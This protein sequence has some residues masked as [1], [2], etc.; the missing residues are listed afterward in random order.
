MGGDGCST[1]CEVETNFA[2]YGSSM[3]KSK[4]I[5]LKYDIEIKLISINKVFMSNQGVF[6]FK[7]TPFLSS[8]LLLDLDKAVNFT[9][10]RNHS[11]LSKSI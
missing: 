5:Y 6:K 8:F 1:I 3:D 10:E 7:I 9:T 2:C 4:C 11:I